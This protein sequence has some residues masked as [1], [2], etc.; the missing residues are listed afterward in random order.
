MFE[1]W[2]LETEVGA[3]PPKQDSFFASFGIENEIEKE[4]GQNII[5]IL[6]AC[7]EKMMVVCHDGR[8][9]LNTNWDVV[10]PKLQDVYARIIDRLIYRPNMSQHANYIMDLIQMCKLAKNWKQK[11][12]SEIYLTCISGAVASGYYGKEFDM[13]ADIEAE[14]KFIDTETLDELDKLGKWKIDANW[15]E[16]NSFASLMVSTR[17]AS[18]FEKDTY[19]MSIREAIEEL[20]TKIKKSS[21]RN[22]ENY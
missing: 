1:M 15:L 10:T 13:D 9:W 11:N 12:T 22:D 5:E 6:D 2:K 7:S 3:E 19:T 4:I 8:I 16:Y 14:A 20:F 17:G 18:S 21:E